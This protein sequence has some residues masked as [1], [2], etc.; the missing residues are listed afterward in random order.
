MR[1]IQSLLPDTSG[2]NYRPELMQTFLDGLIQW[3]PALNAGWQQDDKTGD[4]G[5]ERW[6]ALVEAGLTGVVT[7]EDFGGLD[8]S[9]QEL[10]ELLETL[11]Y[12]CEDAGLGFSL[13]THLCSTCLP[14][15]KFGSDALKAD[16]LPQLV[17]AAQVGAHA[18]TEPDSGSDAFAMKTE[19]VRD[20]DDYILN[21]EKCYISNAPVADICVVYARTHPT[22]GALGGFSAFAVD[23]DSP[24]FTIGKKRSKMGL[25]TAPMADLYFNN[26][27]V[28]VSRLI[29]R[30]GQ[31]FAILD[32]VMR[33]EILCVFAIQVGEM[34]RQLE[35][36]VTY[37]KER[38]QFG[39]PI[40]SYQAISHRI[41]DMHMRLQS[42]RSWL[43][44]MVRAMDGG[45]Q[46][47]L[48]IASAKLAISEAHVA[49]SIDAIT[50]HGGSG[51]MSE[52]GIESHLR[53][54]MGG[55]IYS[56]SSDIQKN[57][58]AAMLGL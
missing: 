14:I 51:Y 27:R 8:L 10:T 29:G 18:I 56:G 55:L 3:A 53:N 52:T 50:L 31:G 54:A 23:C 19:A 46:A 48:E 33:W 45:G 16:L 6:K 58:I 43:S 20:G 32:Y 1:A 35:R 44:R 34:R 4:F 25:R 15:E 47:S 12:I 5:H 39:A 41:A 9:V 30:E 40:A 7:S 36:S 13:A 22:K 28:P 38:K 37:A 26:V 11:G 17:E 42:A 2:G 24:G 49:N 57:R 21:G